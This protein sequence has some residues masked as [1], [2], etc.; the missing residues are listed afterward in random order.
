MKIDQRIKLIVGLCLFAAAGYAQAQ[1]AVTV[2]NHLDKDVTVKYYACGGIKS[3]INS[4]LDD[5]LICRVEQGSCIILNKP[6]EFQVPRG[7]PR[8]E[9]A[10]PPLAQ[11][12]KQEKSEK[13]S[14]ALPPLPEGIKVKNEEGQ[15]VP[16]DKYNNSYIAFTPASI[17]G[18]QTC[19]DGSECTLSSR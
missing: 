17:L 7:F 6:S 10:L 13:L 4:S 5:L 1:V 12:I 19:K 3:T 16:V 2:V 9:K 18:L 11:Q 14:D 8:C 15:W